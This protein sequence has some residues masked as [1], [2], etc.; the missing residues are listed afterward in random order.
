VD[1]TGQDI[2]LVE[3]VINTGVTQRYSTEHLTSRGAASVKLCTLVDKPDGRRVNIIPDWKVFES[4]HDFIFGYG[5]GFN[6]QWRQLPYLATLLREDAREN[7][8]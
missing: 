5:L 6:N 4:H 2:I 8:D 7:S 1:V 3:G